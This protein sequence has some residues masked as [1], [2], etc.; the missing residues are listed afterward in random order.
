MKGARIYRLAPSP[1]AGSSLERAVANLLGDMTTG[2][3]PRLRIFVQ[4]APLTLNPAIQ[5]RL[6]LIVHEAAT[7]ALR[8][9]EAT[10]IEGEVQ[11]LHDALRVVVRDNGC[12]INP[13]AF[14]RRSDLH[15]G[16]CGVRDQ[17]E[18]IGAQF[19]IRSK[20]GVGPKCASPFLKL[21]DALSMAEAPRRRDVVTRVVDIP[22]RILGGRPSTLGRRMCG[23]DCGG[24]RIVR[25]VDTDHSGATG[26]STAM[27]RAL[28]AARNV[29]ATK[30]AARRVHLWNNG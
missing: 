2:R 1:P 18:R 26:I 9:S 25:D 10:K 5:Q 30:M 14:Q 6:F 27:I 13:E 16:L 4:G 21:R 3:V 19:G 28:P 20:P 29:I 7:N 12:G 17:A 23:Q 11:Y 15:R 24:R 22:V 8:H